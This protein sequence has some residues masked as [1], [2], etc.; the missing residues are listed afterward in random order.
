MTDFIV[1][2]VLAVILGSASFYVYKA[3]KNGS[4]CIGCSHA[5]D[6]TGCMKTCGKNSKKEK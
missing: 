1:I 2:L 5:K 4:K 3:K 6:C